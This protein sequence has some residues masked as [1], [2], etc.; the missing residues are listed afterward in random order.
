MPT[1]VELV[2][3]QHKLFDGE[4][5][6]VVMRTEGGDIMFLP[7]HADFVGAVDVCVLRIAPAGADSAEA[8]AEMGG[9]PEER[10]AVAGGFVHVAGNSITVV[11]S[12][13]ELALDIDIDRAKRALASAEEAAAAGSGDGAQAAEAE[14]E[15]VAA[16]PVH[17]S[18]MLALLKPDEP[19]VRAR[20]ARARLEAAGALESLS[21]LGS[22][23]A[24]H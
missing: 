1:H 8:S 3:P 15:G 10:A 24:P 11:A 6:F 9:G 13:A 17:G 19:E 16:E 12:V 4:A 7:N 14:V 21:S 23:V 18:A 5:E 22:P 2:T 20:R